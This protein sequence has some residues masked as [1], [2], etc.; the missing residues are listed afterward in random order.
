MRRV[1]PPALQE[2]VVYTVLSRSPR[3]KELPVTRLAAILILLTGL[4]GLTYQAVA[5]EAKLPVAVE[6]SGDDS[7]GQRLAFAVREAVRSSSGYRLTQGRDALL[8][9]TLVTIEPERD[10]SSTGYWTAAAVAF[11]M[12]NDLPLDQSDPQTWYPIY[13]STNVVLAGAN[14]VEG[15]AKGI[16]ASLDRLVDDYRKDM[17]PR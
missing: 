16:L 7:I 11:T 17:R 2:T 8:T 1:A 6:H 15:Q 12:R 9:I 4:L 5:Q 14:R 13:L 3:P 10:R